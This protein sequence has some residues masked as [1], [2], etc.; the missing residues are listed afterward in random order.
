MEENKEISKEPEISPLTG[1]K[2]EFPHANL[3]GRPKGVKN[4]P[5]TVFDRFRKDPAEELIKI[6]ALLRTCPLEYQRKA[7]EAEMKIWMELLEYQ[8]AKRKPVT[9]KEQK[10]E[11]SKKAADVAFNLLKELEKETDAH[12]GTTGTSNPTSVD[13]GKSDLQA[14]TSPEKDLQDGN[15]E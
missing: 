8:K 13:S 11:E 3:T 1:R 7:L 9:E 2:R 14:E 15:G 12:T 5:K 4:K 6:A 10:Q